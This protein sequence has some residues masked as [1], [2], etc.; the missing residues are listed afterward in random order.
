VNIKVNSTNEGAITTTPIAAGVRMY[1]NQNQD[2]GILQMVTEE[3]T[4]EEEMAPEGPHVL[5][6]VAFTPDNLRALGAQFIG[7]ANHLDASPE[8]EEEV[9]DADA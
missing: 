9:S 2:H 5:A 1:V 7:M 8:P 3:A 4:G 6:Q